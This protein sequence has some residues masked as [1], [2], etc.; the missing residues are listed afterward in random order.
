MPA[1]QL[2]LPE[3]HYQRLKQAAQNRDTA[4]DEL[5]LEAVEA[6]LDSLETGTD[7][8]ERLAYK[9]TAWQKRLAKPSE[10]ISR[11]MEDLQLEFIYNSEAIEGS[12]LS[13]SEIE[14]VVRNVNS[15]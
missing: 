6:F 7:Q 9:Q 12:P 15:Y 11:T 10:K 2:T 5:V 4:V 8:F 3:I 13:K 1:V 14:Q